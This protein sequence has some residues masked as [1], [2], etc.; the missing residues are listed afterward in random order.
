MIQPINIQN[1]RPAS[2]F[3]PTASTT[4]E[5]K[6]YLGAIKVRW[7]F[8]R[9]SYRVEPG[10]YKV[11]KPNS[12][13]DVLVTSNYKLTFDTVRK[14][15][16]SIDAWLL[17]LDTRGVNVWCAA[18]KGTFGT[19]ELVKRIKAHELDKIVNH[20]KIIVPQLGAVGIAAHEVKESTG[21]RVV[22][23]P[24]RAND[25]KPFIEAGYKA[26]PEMRR[27]NFPL[28][29]RVKLIPVELT[30]GKYYLLLIPAIFFI[31][32]GLNSSGYS[33]DKA[34]VSGVLAFTN[35]LG[36]Y[37][38]GCVL[39]PILLP[40]IPFRRFSLKG[41]LLGW[42]T[43]AIL[44]YFRVLG[45]SIIEIISWFLIMGGISSFIAMNFTGASTFTSLSGV[46]KE[47][48]LA[49]PLQVA[50]V[51]IGFIGWIITRFI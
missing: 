23:G 15:L 47:M 17:V 41:L 30:Y 18:G 26:T 25:I 35:L 11:G 7:G 10:I 20:K 50:A 24:V 42:L 51:S 13:S 6:D 3:I 21:F 9:N 28:R 46:K 19:K 5:F 22:Y 33:F 16:K 29:E 38:A 34:L 37:I 49:L 8:G 4:L 2:F 44:I 36:A 45:T 39:N 12:N 27:V 40:W 14:N 1:L 43:A 48:K 31:L 32:S